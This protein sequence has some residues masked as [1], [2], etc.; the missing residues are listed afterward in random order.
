MRLFTT[1][2]VLVACMA[3]APFAL[4]S[5]VAGSTA[6]AAT[7]GGS[8]SSAASSD[9][10]SGANKRIVQAR[11]D[12]A[13]FVASDGAIRGARLEAAFAQLRRDDAAVTQDDLALARYILSL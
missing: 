3:T 9:S 8:A 10:S 1:T 7:G 2:L 12:A 13:R 5:S 11:P 4:A 6:G